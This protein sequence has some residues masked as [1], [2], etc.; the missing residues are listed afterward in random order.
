MA[1]DNVVLSAHR[2]LY[3]AVN[4]MCDAHAPGYRS[5]VW[6]DSLQRALHF[7]TADEA[8]KFADHYGVSKGYAPVTL[9]VEHG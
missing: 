7:A 8:I 4:P 9:G 1:K 6:T 2:G 3:I 5:L